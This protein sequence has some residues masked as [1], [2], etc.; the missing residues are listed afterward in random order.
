MNKVNQKLYDELNDLAA[1]GRSSVVEYDGSTMTT[2]DLI[3][4]TDN[5]RL[6]TLAEVKILLAEQHRNTR[7]DAIDIVLNS[8]SE[9]KIRSVQ[10]NV[11]Q[12]TAN[13]LN[14]KQRLP[15]L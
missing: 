8:F 12:S 3:N 13:I 4:H 15:K 2:N 14:L 7:H 6:Y 5:G 11:Q 1:L 9:E 10:E